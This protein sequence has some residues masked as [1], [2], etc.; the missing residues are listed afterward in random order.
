MRALLGAVV[1]V[2]LLFKG[3]IVPVMHFCPV[4]QT[5]S[6]CLHLVST[7]ILFRNPYKTQ[8]DFAGIFSHPAKSFVLY[9]S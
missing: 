1:P 8:K 5:I 4:K 9:Y 3:T 6:F 7:A 2:F